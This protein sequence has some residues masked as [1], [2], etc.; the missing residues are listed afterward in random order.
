MNLI[1]KLKMFLSNI[2][3]KIFRIFKSIEI[4]IGDVNSYQFSLNKDEF[5]NF[6]PTSS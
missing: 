6:N 2:R 3:I 5:I 4:K 1:K